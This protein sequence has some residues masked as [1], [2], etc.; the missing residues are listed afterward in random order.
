VIVFCLALGIYTHVRALPVLQQYKAVN[1]R[2]VEE[3]RSAPGQAILRESPFKGYSRFLFTLPMKSDYFFT[4][5]YIWRAYFDKENVQFVSDSVY[6]RLHDGRLHDGAIA[7]PFKADRPALYGGLVAFPDQDYMLLPLALD[8]LPTAYQV[9][10][11]YWNDASQ[12]LTQAERDYRRRHALTGKSDPFGYYPLRYDGRVFMVL[13]L[14]DNN[15][16]S[17]L[18]LL[19]Y[20]G[21][22]LLTLYRLSPNPTAVEAARKSR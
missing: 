16:S 20:A 2:V 4:N 11:A 3:I 7:M 9:G 6:V 21:D 8:T 15:V 18:L 19:D 22:E 1:E 10:T 17:A 12:A 5:E 13:P 14:L